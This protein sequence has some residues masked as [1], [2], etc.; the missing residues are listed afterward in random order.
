M[1]KIIRKRDGRTVE[2]E[3][4]K[5]TNAVRKALQKV[6][7]TREGIAEE[8]AS[9]VESECSDS[10]E[11]VESVQ[12]KVEKALIEKNLPEAAK[13]Y[14]LYRNKRTE[15]REQETS[16]MKT[17]NGFF[18]EKGVALKENAN[19]NGSSVGG[20]FYRIG[21]EASKAYYRAHMMSPDVRKEIE[22]NRIH[23]HDEDF[24]GLSVNCMQHSLLDMFKKGFYS[25][26]CFIS[27]PQ[28]ITTAM[29]LT[30]VILQSGQT[31]LFGG[32]STPTW[33]YCMEPYVQKSFEK[34]FSKYLQRFAFAP[35]ETQ[36]K[37]VKEYLYQE[38]T[39]VFEN[40]DLYRCYSWAKKDT[41][42][43]TYQAAQ[44]M[45]FNLNGLCSR[46]GGQTVFSSLNF[47][48]C[49]K[50]G[51]R[52]A[53]KA[54]LD[55]MDKGIGKGITAIYPI[56]VFKFKSGL[57][58]NPGDPNYDL[59]LMS[60]KVT[61][62][63]QFPNY[64]N[65]D[66]PYNLKYYKEGHPETEV[67]Y[68]GCR[69]RVIANVNGPE[70]VTGR[71]NLSFTSINLP[72]LAIEASKEAEEMNLRESIFFQKLDKALEIA[73][74]QLQERFEI[75]CKRK[76]YNFPYVMQQGAYMGSEYLAPTDEVRKALLNGTLSFGFVGLAECL[77]A[78]TGHDH[79]EGPQYQEL[80][81][82]IVK[83]MR[84]YAD[85]LTEERHMNWTLI[86]TPAESLAGK[87][88]RKDR[89]E[90]GII[91]GITDKDYYTNSNHVPVG[92]KVTA[93]EKIR[94]EAPYH[95]LCNAGAILYIEIEGDPRNNPEVIHTLNNQMH[96]AG[97]G[98]FSYN[99][100]MD[101][102]TAC[103]FVGLIG[104]TC[105]SC[106]QKGTPSTPIMRPRRL[107]GYLGYEDRFNSAKL[108]ELHD[109]VTHT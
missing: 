9:L 106:G 84:Q 108:A 37:W 13:E 50:P 27:E 89:E 109:R 88:L 62:K 79:T 58:F 3:K 80:G 85:K 61:A 66:A 14:I 15:I 31:D 105:P 46:V 21:S 82:K 91:P 57:T 51:G 55:A 40:D 12:D 52:L 18:Q 49:T 4:Q 32:E 74:K 19:I 11:T 86:A 22:E 17:I 103:G 8:I 48:T 7:E 41:E 90:F 38:H 60:E 2:F 81:L 1:A 25:G 76:V 26:N 97:V 104:D 102:C 59:R 73:A 28:S 30:C 6:D 72:R 53:T 36:K 94:I 67:A 23:P 68:M 92:T 54:L 45:L 34:Y 100:K 69:T 98:Y 78:L 5:I 101:T 70:V 56:P 96:D 33:D 47:G 24:Y 87:F 71:G 20:T 93:S 35:V 64:S 65:L 39:P 107:T 10:L 75:Q 44:S 29:M 42:A 77:R 99:I 16:L 83:Y 95:A 43:E 63:R